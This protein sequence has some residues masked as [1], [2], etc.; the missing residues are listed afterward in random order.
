MHAPHHAARTHRRVHMRARGRK[1][2]SG[3]PRH[4]THRVH[5][6]AASGAAL[7]GDAAVQRCGARARGW[8]PTTTAPRSDQPTLYLPYK[9][10]PTLYLPIQKAAYP[11]PL[12]TSAARSPPTSMHFWVS[13]GL[14]Q[15][16]M[17][18]SGL[19]CTSPY[20]KRPTLHLPVQ[21]PA[22]PTPV[23]HS[24]NR[25]PPPPATETSGVG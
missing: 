19:P 1:G 22:Y 12:S 4:Q 8:S 7:S 15:F 25:E 16:C 6:C 20:K 23:N 14:G 18:E 13:V 21:H 17:G 24:V 10:Q 9:I 5:A 2:T 3:L 11:A